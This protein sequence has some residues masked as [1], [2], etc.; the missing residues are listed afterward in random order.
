MQTTYLNNQEAVNDQEQAKPSFYALIPATVRYC[1]DIPMGA[2]MLWGELFALTDVRGYCFASSDHFSRLYDVDRS[3]ITRWLTALVKLKF[4]TIE[5]IAGTKE[6]RIYVQVGLLPESVAQKCATDNAKM[7]H[8]QCKN[9]PH[10]IKE[11]I[12]ESITE[13]FNVGDGR[14]VGPGPVPAKELK[15]QKGLASPASGTEFARRQQQVNEVVAATGD[16]KSVLRF[17]QLLDVAESSS[18]GA[19]WDEALTALADAQKRPAGP[20]ERPGAYF[21]SVLVAGL[22]ARG[23]AVPVGSA[24]ERR[25]VKSQIAKSLSAAELKL[26]P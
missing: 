22:N 2:K 12:T 21:C 7:R 9:A 3:T 24:S 6:R 19:A 5:H 25:S 8:T 23:V 16:A 26:L 4:I 14:F 18:C 11:N 20:V 15:E 17:R 13:T 10:S 1:S